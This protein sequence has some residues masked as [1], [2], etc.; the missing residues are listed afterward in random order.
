MLIVT[1]LVQ[2]KVAQQ[3]REKIQGAWVAISFEF[4]GNKIPDDEIS[5]LRWK[6]SRTTGRFTAA[7][8]FPR[9][10]IDWIRARSGSSSR[11]RSPRGQATVKRS[12]ESMR[13]TETF[14]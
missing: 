7:P 6:S 12:W 4:R 13:C 11:A 14:G 2:E 3:D 8:R 10:P 1:A 9:G 5:N